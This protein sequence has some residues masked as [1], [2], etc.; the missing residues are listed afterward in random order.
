MV[1]L[2][3]PFVLGVVLLLARAVAAPLLNPALG[4]AAKVTCS[5]VLLGGATVEQVTAGFP[6]ERLAR[7]VGVRLDAANGVVDAG[8]PL[9]GRRRAVHRPGAGCTLVPV[10][11][12]LTPL[13]A[14]VFPAQPVAGGSPEVPWPEGSGVVAAPASVSAARLDAV[15]DSAFAEEAGAPPRR[16][17]AVVIVHDG[18]VIAER[19]A[20]GYS[21]AHRFAGWSM[22]KSVTNAL[23]GILAGD[24]RLE[25]TA[26]GL[27]PEWQSP[28]D[29]RAGIT[30]GQLM[31]MSSGLDFEESYSP[32]GGATRMLFN[33]A[34]VAAAAAE[35]PLREE[36]GSTWY[37]SSGTTNLISAH[38][39]DLMGSDSAYLRLPA[40]RLFG[41]VGMHSAVLEP[42][43]A[44]TFVGSSFMY[45]TAQDWARFG[46]LYLR[47]GEWNGRRIL[48]AGWVAWSMRP[49]PAAPLGRYGAQWWLNA[50]TAAD[51]RQRPYP[52]LP[53]DLYWASGFQGQYVAV[54]P[55]HD[56]VVV[57]LGAAA[58]DGGWPL[59]PFLRSVLAAMRSPASS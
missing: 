16:T 24:G 33:S 49:A 52:Y 6:D 9:L 53:Q 40:E 45:A 50:G 22:A 44:G 21:R 30:L 5:G 18:R 28:G 23:A 37:Y 8:V 14:G 48:P 59:G 35:T 39:R 34:D 2:A 46:L 7:V 17:Y 29:A 36:P 55:S 13:P 57:R 11:G 42:D 47:D 20:P 32:Q 51:P 31:H 56:L 19:Y 38:L 27:R 25:L 12:S 1:L 4:F 54:L 26:A 10:R 43:A 41:P 58:T 3:L 15:L